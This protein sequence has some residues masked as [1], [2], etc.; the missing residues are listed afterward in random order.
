M[1]C[2][3]PMVLSA[4]PYDNLHHRALKVQEI[5]GNDTVP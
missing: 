3:L 1:S 2:L 4:I 5:I